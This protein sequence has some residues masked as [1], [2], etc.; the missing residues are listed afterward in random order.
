MSLTNPAQ[1]WRER[2][3]R[4]AH[5][6]E[7]GTIVACTRIVEGVEPLPYTAGLVAFG[8]EQVAGQ[9]VSVHGE[10]KP[11]MRVVGVLR[12]V[13]MGGEAGVIEYGVKYEVIGHD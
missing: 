3:E 10:P 13:G 1:V 2:K 12:R 8:T 4:Y 11:G 6:G 5:L 7:V 9:I